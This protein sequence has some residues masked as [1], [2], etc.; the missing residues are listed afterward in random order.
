MPEAPRVQSPR[1]PFAARIHVITHWLSPV[2]RVLIR[3]LGYY[4]E[5]ASGWVVLTTTGRKSGLPRHVLLP[6]E[7]TSEFLYVISTYG[8]RSNWLRNMARDP[9]VMVTCGGWRVAGHVEIV[10][11]LERK[12]AIVSGHPFFPAAPFAVVHAVVRT[13]LRPLLIA[14]LRQ[15]MRPRPVVVVYP[16]KIVAP[17]RFDTVPVVRVR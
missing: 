13:I 15:W 2:H 6:C 5:R 9:R 1:E 14:F 4:F 10:D 16:Q 7:R 3:V 17:E 11:D 8:R 12:R